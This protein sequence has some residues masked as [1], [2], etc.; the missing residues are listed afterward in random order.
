MSKYAVL[1]LKLRSGVLE[2]AVEEVAMKLDQE[3]PCFVS[4][5]VARLFGLVKPHNRKRPA[6]RVHDDLVGA[7]SFDELVKVRRPGNPDLTEGH[8]SGKAKMVV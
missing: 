8:Q 3:W 1:L 7:R 6:E 5:Q 2:L 4:K